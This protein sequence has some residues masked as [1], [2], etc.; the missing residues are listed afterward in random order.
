MAMIEL[1]DYKILGWGAFISLCISI[2]AYIFN[3]FVL[4]LKYSLILSFIIFI[5]GLLFTYLHLIVDG[6]QKSYGTIEKYSSWFPIFTSYFDELGLGINL[7][8]ES[9]SAIGKKIASRPDSSYNYIAKEI[10]ERATYQFA[11]LANDEYRTSGQNAVETYK[12]LLDRLKPGERY[13]S[14]SIVGIQNFWQGDR[15]GTP[16]FEANRNAISRGVKIE[17]I[18]ILYKDEN[19]IMKGEIEK[20]INIGA[21]VLVVPEEFLPEEYKRDFGIFNDEVVGYL[22]LG[23]QESFVGIKWYFAPKEIEIAKHLFE[24]IAEYSASYP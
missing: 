15:I 19:N 17:R 7:I 8:L 13:L 12:K 9:I 22:E 16:I 5:L 23:S 14:T 18:F 21:K 10:I 6:I 3:F 2:A 20:Q 24:M 11:E 1:V 4:D